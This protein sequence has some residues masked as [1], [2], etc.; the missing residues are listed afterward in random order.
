MPATSTDRLDGLTTSV[1]VKAPVQAVATGNLTLAAL[2]TVGGVA[3]TERDRVL[4]TGQTDATENGIWLA[5]TGDWTRSLDFDGARDVVNGT[6]I[7]YVVD[8]D[9]GALYQVT[10]PDDPI[11]IGQSELTIE[12]RENPTAPTLQ[13]ASDLR[14]K[15]TGFSFVTGNIFSCDGAGKASHDFDAEQDFLKIYGSLTGANAFWV[16][17][18]NGSDGNSGAFNAPY[19]TVAVAMANSAGLGLIWLMPGVYTTRF[20]TRASHNLTGG[21]ARAVRIKAWGGPGTVIFKAAGQ[22]PGAMVWTFTGGSG[23]EYEAT[24]TGGEDAFLLL[25]REDDREIPLQRY[26]S[27]AT[28]D[29]SGAGWYQDPATKKIFVR[30]GNIDFSLPAHADRLEIIYI[31]ATSPIVHGSRIYLEGVTFRGGN[32]FLV[33]YETTHRPTF[34][35]RHCKWQYLGY[36]NIQLFG[37]LSLFQDCT[38][39]YSLG[40]D[41]WN[42]ENDPGTGQQCEAI[43]VDCI[44]RYNGIPQSRDFDGDRNKQGSSGHEDSVILRVNGEYYLNYSYSIGDTGANSKTWMVGTICG[45][46]FADLVSGGIGGYIA[47]YTEGEAH[48]DCV[49]SGGRAS[50][51]GLW[52]ESNVARLYRCEFYGTTANI[53]ANTGSTSLYNPVA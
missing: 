8:T 47:T 27:A 29:A 10:S 44:G 30:F 23:A 7:P 16:D 2:Q 13:L 36:H 50:T 21:Q 3:L 26:S 53:G 33:D 19:L 35:A 41:G 38:S 52:V 24:P 32:E 9:I 18:V 12:L 48:L 42:Y 46:P 14:T 6:L 28:A 40:G 31:Q 34:F 1:A 43:E 5:S 45:N 39:E 17:P 15:P 11:I 37:V 25:Y 49:R 4:T 22:Q 51:Y 20:D